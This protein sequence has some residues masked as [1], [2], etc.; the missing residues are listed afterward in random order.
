MWGPLIKYV[1]GKANIIADMLSRPPITVNTI[2]IG[3]VPQGTLRNHLKRAYRTDPFI[4][5]I[6]QYL[7]TPSLDCNHLMSTAYHPQT[8]GQTERTIRILKDMIR[9][10]CNKKGNDWDTLLVPLEF[11]YNNS[12]QSS[13]QQTPFYLNNG[14]LP[15]IPETLALGFQNASNMDSGRRL[16][17]LAKSHALAKKCLSLAQQKQ[18]KY[19]NENRKSEEFQIGQLVWLSTRYLM[20]E[21]KPWNKLQ[22]KWMGPF[23]V[24]KKISDNAVKINSQDFGHHFHSVVNVSRLKPYR[25]EAPRT[26]SQD[27][28]TVTEPAN[29][30]I[31]DLPDEDFQ[32]AIEDEE[33]HE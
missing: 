13:T 32:V 5:S 3:C 10:F 7:G 25:G 17:K 29:Q 22:P 30:I 16:Q 1:E 26:G 8:D 23:Q 27:E 28:V 15:I 12:Y 31:E 14:R 11:A 6:Q 18:I 2:A 4:R 20:R 19:A 9:S 24:I 21:G 33:D